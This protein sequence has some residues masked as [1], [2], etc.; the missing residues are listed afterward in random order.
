[1]PNQK[2]N[3]V[4]EKVILKYLI[5]ALFL[6]FQQFDSKI[7]LVKLPLIYFDT[8]QNVDKHLFTALGVATPILKST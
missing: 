5:V 2:N 8:V 4:F 1:M 7:I 3:E 6:N